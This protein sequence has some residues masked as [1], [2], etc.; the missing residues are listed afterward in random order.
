[1]LFALTAY[2]FPMRSKQMLRI[3]QRTLLAAPKS[4]TQERRQLAHFYGQEAKP[5]SRH[6]SQQ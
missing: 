3:A 4:S 1:M 2:R 6:L 5:H